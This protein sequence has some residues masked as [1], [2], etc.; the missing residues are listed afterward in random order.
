MEIFMIK[1]SYESP[2]NS[3][4][5][6]REMKYIFS[7]DKKFKTWR[8]LWVALAE[9][10]MELGLSVTPGKAA[11][12]EEAAPAEETAPAAEEAAPAEEAATEE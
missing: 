12:A 3:R 2:L 10:E 6:S 11:A 5:A 4:Y 9:S 8:R 1:D 7:P